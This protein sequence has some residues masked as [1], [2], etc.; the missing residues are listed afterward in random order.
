M[1]YS[2][3]PAK[4]WQ[5]CAPKRVEVSS[6]RNW[7]PSRDTIDIEIQHDPSLDQQLLRLS[8]REAEG[9]QEA[10]RRVLASEVSSSWSPDVILAELPK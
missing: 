10:L 8:R 5:R 3:G 4:H 2:Y 6:V 1:A 7:S 9:L